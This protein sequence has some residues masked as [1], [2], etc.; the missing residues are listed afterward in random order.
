MGQYWKIVNATKKLF[1]CPSAFG[2]GIKYDEI[3]YTPI[4]LLLFLEKYWF[5]DK[6]FFIGDYDNN[7]EKEMQEFYNPNVEYKKYD[8]LY[9]YLMNNEFNYYDNR[10]RMTQDY[11][12][13][14]DT[15][16]N[17]KCIE[18]P[19]LQYYKD[20]IVV[21]KEK[22]EYISVNKDYPD[23]I[24]AVLAHNNSDNEF[25]F[26]GLWLN[27]SITLYKKT[28]IDISDYKKIILTSNF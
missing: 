14:V 16:Y 27:S 11:K 10:Y 19:T 15:F 23:I 21:N 2:D 1:I 5:N 7:T 4:V 24:K 25:K 20:Y 3:Y 18:K 12:F 17:N 13:I 8:N 9:H 28:D 22:K 26:S 6:I